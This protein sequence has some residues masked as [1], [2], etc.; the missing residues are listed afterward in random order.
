MNTNIFYATLM[1]G[2]RERVPEFMR[3]IIAAKEK[4]VLL[5]RD[6]H[7]LYFNMPYPF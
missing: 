4:S 1:V 2:F 6:R 5:I 7:F 3:G